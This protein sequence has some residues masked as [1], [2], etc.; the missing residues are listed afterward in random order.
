MNSY[1][2][3]SRLLTTYSA[4]ENPLHFDKT[5]NYLFD[6]SYLSALNVQGDKASDF[7]QGQLSCEMQDLSDIHMVHGAQCNLKGRILALLD[8]V[9]WNGIQLILPRDL[10]EATQNSLMKTA[11][12]SRVTLTEN[13]SFKIF[14]FYLQNPQDI[15]PHS[16]FFP[17]A[18]QGQTYNEQGCYYHLGQNFYILLLKSDYVEPVVSIFKTQQQLFGSLTWH[19]LRLMQ[20]QIEIYPESR[21]LFLPHRLGLHDTSYIS[22]NKGCYKGQEIIA[23]MHY[24]STLKHELKLFE[25]ETD[26][27]LFSGQKVF[28]AEKNSEIGELVDYTPLDQQRFLVAVSIL[29]EIEELNHVVWSEKLE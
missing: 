9:K 11:L 3:N 18:I 22:F 23:R 7:L 8:V 24:K 10:L 26:G 21:G 5:K 6:L 14:G 12:L 2:I 17:E 25:I 19:S 27:P 1:T 29:K 15:K 13:S 28:N 4:E 20:G 16:S